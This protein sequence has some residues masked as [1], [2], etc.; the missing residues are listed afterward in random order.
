MERLV[1]ICCGSYEDALNAYKGKAKRIELNSALYLGG[2]TPSLASLKLTKK[3]TNL[4]VIT[5]VRPRGA[6]FYY[7]DIEFEV[8]KEDARCLLE[9]G[10]DGIAFGCLNE[11]GTIHEKQTKEMID[12]I[13]EYQGEVVFHRAFDCVKDPYV[14][15]ELLIQLGVDRILTSGLK[16]KAMDGKQIEILA[17]SGINA[18]NAREMMNDTGINQVHSSCKDWINDPTT[19][20]HEVSYSYAPAPH[21]ND[22]DVVSIELVEEIERSIQK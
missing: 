20:T 14:S 17:G 1:E 5:M 9:N 15:I 8:M 10:A 2:L 11:D 3:N 7:N 13:K 12:I 19:K 6:G 22:Y 18:S 21:E 16:P 4:K